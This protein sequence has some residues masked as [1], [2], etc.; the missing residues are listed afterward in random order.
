MEQSNELFESILTLDRGI[1]PL[2]HG[3]VVVRLER[4]LVEVP[5]ILNL[6]VHILRP[7]TTPCLT[8]LEDHGGECVQFARN[9]HT[10]AEPDEL[11]CLLAGLFHHSAHRTRPVHRDDDTVVLP[12]GSRL[13]TQED[14]IV[15]LVVHQTFEVDFAR[16]RSHR[17]AIFI[18]TLLHLEPLCH[19]SDHLTRLA[20]ER[21]EI[22]THRVQFNR[23][24]K[25][26]L[27]LLGIQDFL[28]HF[29][30][31]GN[32]THTVLDVEGRNLTVVPC[33]TILVNEVFEVLVHRTLRLGSSRTRSGIVTR[34][35]LRT[36]TTSVVAFVVA[37]SRSTFGVLLFTVFVTIGVV[38]ITVFVVGLIVTGF[39]V[40]TLAIG[41][42]HVVHVLIGR[43][44]FA[45]AIFLL[46]RLGRQVLVKRLGDIENFLPT[47]ALLNGVH[48]CH[49]FSR[50][51]DTRKCATLEVNVETVDEVE[52]VRLASIKTEEVTL[53]HLAVPS[54]EVALEAGILR[55][56]VSLDASVFD[57]VDEILSNIEI[58]T[59]VFDVAHELLSVLER[60]P[61]GVS[62][63]VTDEHIVKR[64]RHRLPDRK[65]KGTRIHREGS[66][67]GSCIVDDGDVFGGHESGERVDS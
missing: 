62:D 16:E 17:V 6:V 48:E 47:V 26:S 56:D 44:I 22:S 13:V 43:D 4:L 11:K 60:R 20:S 55:L 67:S 7:R 21:L 63:F 29:L 5:T 61:Q 34:T 37:L 14:V 54:N 27:T 46:L 32:G 39:G 49:L 64:I 45:F 53:D 1:V 19:L 65:R 23:S 41:V 38:T 9:V 3:Q 30:Q 12:L 33:R 51:F 66:R 59:N 24:R 35:S 57:D 58:A 15:E 10:F 42:F 28:V 36:M 50:E 18:G 52:V 40:H 8:S 25:V 31:L 2:K